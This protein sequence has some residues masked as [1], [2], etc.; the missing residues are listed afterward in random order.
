MISGSDVAFGRK[1]VLRLVVGV[2][3]PLA[4]VACATVPEGV[5]EQDLARYDS[6][7]QS[8]G[9]TIVTEP[10]Y[11]AVGM[12][13][14]LSRAQLLDITAYK[15]SSHAAKRLPDGGV[16]LTTGACA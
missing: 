15:L 12:Q 7:V 14:G 11:L 3:A 4:L 8:L 5:S 1:A 9:C 16:E 2:A 6:A 13:T 10:D